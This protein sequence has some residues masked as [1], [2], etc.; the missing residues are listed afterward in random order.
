[1]QFNAE[2]TGDAA[3]L[4][5]THSELLARLPAT[6]S[7]FILV[8]LQKWPLLFAPEQRYQRTLLEQLARIPH[9]ELEQSAAGISRVE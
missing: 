2:L 7:A 1:M 4:A 5:R 9:G 8:E 6:V 3:A